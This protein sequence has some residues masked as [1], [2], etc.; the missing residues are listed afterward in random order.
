MCRRQF[1]VHFAVVHDS[2]VFKPSIVILT[3]V[4][5]WFKQKY[6]MCKLLHFS[7]SQTQWSDV[8]VH[9]IH[10]IRF[11]KVYVVH[12]TYDSSSSDLQLLLHGMNTCYVSHWE[13]PHETWDR[14][15]TN[16][17]AIW[18]SLSPDNVTVIPRNTGHMK[19][20]FSCIYHKPYFNS[21]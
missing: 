10:W 1:K 15:Y 9:L 2:S 14:Q 13:N 4:C 11:Y 17:V 19:L 8:T 3:S 18:H 16:D 7:L 5:L 6:I 21:V 20:W 12:A